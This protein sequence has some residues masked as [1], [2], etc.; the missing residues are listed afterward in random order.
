MLYE[1]GQIIQQIEATVATELEKSGIIQ[2]L[3]S[4]GKE[5][6]QTVAAQ[7]KTEAANV[8]E[9]GKEDEQLARGQVDNPAK[10]KCR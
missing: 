1:A 10:G 7:A 2:N 4:D 3:E 5:D 8:E 6:E 9:D